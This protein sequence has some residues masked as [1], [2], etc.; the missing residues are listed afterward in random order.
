MEE[1]KA[2][3]LALKDLAQDESAE[4]LCLQRLEALDTLTRV[5]N[6]NFFDLQFETRWKTA[7]RNKETLALFFVDI[8]QFRSFNA[9]NDSRSG[10]YA[11]QKI[12]KTLKLLFRRASD[13][14]ARYK[15][16]QFIIVASNMTQEQAEL[17]AQRICERV[18]N[19]KILDTRPNQFLT[20]CV[21]YIVHSPRAT[22][23]P[24]NTLEAAYQNLKYAKSA[25]KGKSFG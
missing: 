2:L 15:A 13:F 4:N 8:D 18:Y 24:Q 6:R 11:L 21:G 14:V 7:I 19:L 17:Y 20:V 5:Y 12:A 22:G 3:D 16:D 9:R 1:L 10:D 25:G 23:K